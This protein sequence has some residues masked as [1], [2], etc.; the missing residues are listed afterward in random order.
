MLKE[1][2]RDILTGKVRPKPIGFSWKG[3]GDS[4]FRNVGKA[5]GLK[6]EGLDKWGGKGAKES[7]RPKF[8][9]EAEEAIYKDKVDAG[10]IK[11]DTYLR[12]EGASGGK[13]KIGLR[14]PL[15]ALLVSGADNEYSKAE[16]ADRAELAKANDEIARAMEADRETI[17]KANEEISRVTG[18]KE[19]VSL[20]EKS[21][22]EMVATEAYPEESVPEEIATEEAYAEEP[23]SEEKAGEE[24]ATE[25]TYPEEGAVEGTYPE[26]S[27]VE[28]SYAPEESPMEGGYSGK[29]APY[30]PPYE[31]Y[32]GGKGGGGGIPLPKGYAKQLSKEQLL[33]AIGWKQGIMYKYIYPPYGQED[34][35]NSRSPIQG[36]PIKEGI[37]SAY[38]T[39]IRTRKGVIPKNIT[40][41]MGMMTL[42][43]TDADKNGQPEIHFVEREVRK[44]R[45]AVVTKKKPTAEV[46]NM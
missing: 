10:I 29:Y 9:S 38:E 15:G 33:G 4:P 42:V 7:T 31:G 3:S 26:E 12:D 37:R 5:W 35:I 40:R 46:F 14:E 1:N 2:V 41:E 24:T 17:T 36:I 34:I 18:Y 19:E 11:E 13:Y 8:K 45:G 25:G 23:V 30:Q 22:E 43:I 27:A 28:S 6:T 21:S 44:G 32:G 16:E 20:E 39:I